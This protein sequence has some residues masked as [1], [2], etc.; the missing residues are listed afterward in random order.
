[1]I[2][3][4]EILTETPAIEIAG[5]H[6]QSALG[7]ALLEAAQRAREAD[8]VTWITSGGTKIAAVVPEYVGD[9]KDPGSPH[10]PVITGKVVPKPLPSPAVQLALDTGE[11]VSEPAS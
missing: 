11:P 1:M 9:A 3:A 7:K 2:M 10:D 5:R 6:T 8:R 4:A